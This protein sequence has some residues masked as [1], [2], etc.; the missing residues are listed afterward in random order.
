[1]LSR[2][3]SL[4]PEK[5]QPWA[6][7]IKY[8]YSAEVMQQWSKYK[9][10]KSL[11]LYGRKHKVIN[12]PT[13]FKSQSTQWRLLVAQWDKSSHSAQT[14]ASIPH[15]WC[16]DLNNYIFFVAEVPELLL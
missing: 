9:G 2:K 13:L 1:M 12:Y 3:A 10:L 8:I 7:W 11:L 6:E 4:D 5:K 14:T 16:C 15:L